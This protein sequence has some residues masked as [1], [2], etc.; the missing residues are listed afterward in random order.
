[1][2]LGVTKGGAATTSRSDVST[3]QQQPWPL[4]M[5]ALV[6]GMVLGRWR[7]P[8]DT[9]SAR[10]PMPA[11]AGAA[12]DKS[13]GEL[14]DQLSSIEGALSQLKEGRGNSSVSAGTSPR[15]IPRVVSLERQ[16]GTALGAPS[17]AKARSPLGRSPSPRLQEE[18]ASASPPC[19]DR[20]PSSMALELP[21]EQSGI[22]PLTASADSSQ[23]TALPLIVTSTV[24]GERGVQWVDVLAKHECP[25]ITARRAERAQ[26]SGD[27]QDPIV[28]ERT[29]GAN[30]WDVDGN[31]FVD[32]TAG[33]G[34]VAAGHCNPF[35][36][37]RAEKQM[38]TH[39]HGMGDAF[40]GRVRIELAAA[41]ARITPGMLQQTIFASSGSEAVEAAIKTAIMAT[42]RTS[43]LAFEGGY[44]GLALGV[45]AAS[46][47]KES[48]RAPF[49]GAL[50]GYA[51]FLPFGHPPELIEEWL[52]RRGFEQDA[53]T[54]AAAL[55]GGSQGKCPF[56]GLSSPGLPAAILVEPI[57][58][59][60]G[61]RPPPKGWLRALRHLCDQHGMLLI[62]DEV[63]TGFGRAGALFQSGSA[64]AD[65]V[66][67]DLLCL[68]KGLTSGFPLSACVGTPRA[69]GAWGLSKG[70]ALHTS[71]F[72]GHPVGCAAGLAMVELMEGGLLARGVAL[73]NYMGASLEALV[74]ELPQHLVCVRGRG[75]MRALVLR[76]GVMVAL[77]LMRGMLLRGFIVFPAGEAADALSFT[78][79]L[80]LTALQW[81]AA[82]AALRQLLRD[83]PP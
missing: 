29:R 77:Q 3:T 17:A 12:N 83:S 74:L 25:A 47:Y 42:G 10:W 22:P 6:L 11:D 43:V 21:V 73:G 81:D 1:M 65:F 51:A 69:M 68:G 26:R 39:L 71:T 60:G 41:L 75:A 13:L 64:E 31:R 9:R 49:K 79:P 7:R 58:G 78:P 55:L 34:V 52:V 5:G 46:H 57:Q 45:L 63:F 50:G 76:G 62:F 40:P 33:F 37:A 59:R 18:A 67:P 8:L 4:V 2:S 28:W 48:F 44:H 66:V 23:G 35:V 20:P 80:T 54:A 53:N 56:S 36:V 70:E 61:D 32:L 30:V 82:I 72:L 14:Q 38:R 16:P 15:A 19:V 24:P 27:G